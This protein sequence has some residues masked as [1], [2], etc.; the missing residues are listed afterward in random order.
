MQAASK[1]SKG[2]AP[3]ATV[4]IEL[5]LLAKG[6]C[7]LAWLAFHEAI[8][9]PTPDCQKVKPAMPRFPPTSLLQPAPPIYCLLLLAYL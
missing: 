6:K 7:D 8:T 4:P 5:I 3:T 2:A 9:H 1:P